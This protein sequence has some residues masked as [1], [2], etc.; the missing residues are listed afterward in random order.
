MTAREDDIERLLHEGRVH[1]WTRRRPAWPGHSTFVALKG[2]VVVIGDR[3]AAEGVERTYDC[4]PASL[5][6]GMFHDVIADQLG[7]KVLEEVLA[8]VR[9][10]LG[11]A[12]PAIQKAPDPPKIA[13]ERPAIALPPST[14][15][16]PMG[17]AKP[18][19]ASQPLVTPPPAAPKPL[20]TPPPAVTPAP[21]AQRP[22][23]TPPPAVVTPAS[24]A[25]KPVVTP[26]PAAPPPV[27]RVIDPASRFD[28]V[29]VSCGSIGLPLV[30]TLRGITRSPVKELLSGL[31]AL[32]FR[33]VKSVSRDHAE[34]LSARIADLGAEIQI[35]PAA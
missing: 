17:S 14:F 32:P 2:G 35:L 4:D 1:R 18:P 26:P 31:S 28:V 20:V 9:R 34:A 6:E 27:K 19:A 10:D 7:K 33:A 13:A 21:V 16:T 15:V 25:P 29:V 30:V 23:V 12:K 24:V 5:L 11:D 3:Y 8:E 22:P